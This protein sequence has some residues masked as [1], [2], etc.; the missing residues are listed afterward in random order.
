MNN[1]LKNLSICFLTL[2]LAFS[3]AAC[4]GFLVDDNGVDYTI[5]LSDEVAVAPVETEAQAIAIA[6]DYVYK[7]FEED[8]SDYKISCS[9]K[10][11]IW[12]VSY[13]PIV[14][15]GTIILGGGGPLVK[16]DKTSGRVTYCL[17]QK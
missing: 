2:L 5:R 17:L 12:S 10:N 16:I 6:K 14:P 11:D 4:R 15:E 7:K 13:S 8:F 1:Y 9:L 3:F